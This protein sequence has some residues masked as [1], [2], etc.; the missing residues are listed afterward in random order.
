MFESKYS[1]VLTVILIIVIVAI[2]GLLGFLGYDYYQN[3]IVT[4]D[5]SN[6]VDNFQGDV[7]DG[8][9]EDNQD[10]DNANTSDENPFDQIKDS[11]AS[12]S[13]T[14]NSNMCI[15]PYMR[16]AHL[17]FTFKLYSSIHKICIVIIRITIWI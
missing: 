15:L 6:F 10:K 16:K 12:T 5:T 4:K 8:E 3:Y 11:N 9:S 14:T 7:T 2:V 13:K 17:G 1:K